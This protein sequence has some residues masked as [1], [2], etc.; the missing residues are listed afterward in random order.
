[1]T[2]HHTTTPGTHQTTTPTIEVPD[3]ETPAARCSYC[4]RP[5]RSTHL[6]DL[7]LG[8]EHG[9]VVSEDE[10]ERFNAAYDEEGDEL[11]IYHLKVIAA[12]VLLFMGTSYAYAFVWS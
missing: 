3:G 8:E 1:M 11:F 12:L 2:T 9:D 4:E 10:R 5:F 7:H 6:L